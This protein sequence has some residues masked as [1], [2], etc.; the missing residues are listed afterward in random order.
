MFYRVLPRLSRVVS[1]SVCALCFFGCSARGQL[2]ALEAD[3]R[4]MDQ[5]MS[6]LQAQLVSTEAELKVAR[7]D[8][9][10]LRNS[11]AQ[12]QSSIGRLTLE[13]GLSVSN[14]ILISLG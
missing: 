6:D 2:D 5:Q 3:L 14:S 7:R 13:L 4:S 9:E 8:A 1:L 11:M 12:N 10:A